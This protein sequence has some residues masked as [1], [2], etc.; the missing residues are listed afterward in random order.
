MTNTEQPSLVGS[1][2]LLDVL[3]VLLLA[4][5]AVI[6]ATDLYA[7]SL[8]DLPALLNTTPL[9]VKL[10][11][12][13]NVLALGV[14]QLVHGPLSDRY[15]R[16]RMMLTGMAV[17]A[18][19]SVGCS[20]ATNIETL[21]VFRVLQGTAAA[22][23][24]V[25]GLAVIREVFSPTDQVRAF[26]WFGIVIAMV[27]AAAPILGGYVHVH[28]GWRANFWIMAV[29][30][31]MSVLLVWWKLPESAPPDREP[32][33][34]RLVLREYLTL[35]RT[36][37]FFGYALLESMAL[38]SIYAFITVAPFILITRFGVRTERFGLYL[39]VVVAAYAIGSLL[40]ERM[41]S[42]VS[43]SRI[44]GLG[45][46]VYCVGV[47][48][49][50][51]LIAAGREGPVS[52]TALMAVVLFGTGPLFA[53]CPVLALDAAGKRVGVAAALL[54]AMEMGLGGLASVVVSLLPWSSAV[55][56][57]AMLVTLAVGALAARAI[58]TRR[59]D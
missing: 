16:R 39:G 56:L 23:E 54:G 42:R 10:T 59:P 7:P 8:P 15:G 47:V 55:S 1:L 29:A 27:P 5:T 45:I 9:W 51:C 19:A 21:M 17:F 3:P 25:V 46:A 20:L 12:S 4:S 35:L 49:F 31:L 18:L 57:A 43:A 2:T 48:A 28:L 38:A 34:P 36:P 52:I 40:A 13:L 14:T 44:L 22:V 53:T 32:L 58:A 11:L 37:Q 26:A 30:G 41:A 6:M 50:A 33:V 24:A